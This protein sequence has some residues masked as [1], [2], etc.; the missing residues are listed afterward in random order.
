[1]KIILGQGFV[2]PER[3]AVFGWSYGGYMSLMLFAKH[4]NLFRIA[5]AGAPVINWE[6]YDSG[7]TER[8]MGLLSK[9]AQGYSQ[10]SVLHW[11]DQFPDDDEE[12]REEGGRLILVHS[13]ADENVHPQH[14][15]QLIDA[16][17]QHGKPYTF[18]LFPKERHGLRDLSSQVYFE[19]RF[20]K[21]LSRWLVK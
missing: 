14:T 9:N 21:T 11:I 2:N 16:L 17:I 7:Y 15:F 5:I 20:G 6:D 10:S 3:I 18:Y 1:L 4:S 13:L 8:Y 19:H 12:D